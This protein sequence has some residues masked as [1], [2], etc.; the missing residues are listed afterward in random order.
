MFQLPLLVG[1][2]F[3]DTLQEQAAVRY[4]ESNGETFLITN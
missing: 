3:Y 1:L 2:E 4:L